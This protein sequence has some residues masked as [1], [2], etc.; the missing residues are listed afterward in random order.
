MKRY[1]FLYLIVY[2]K[3]VIIYLFFYFLL[4][5]HNAAY[6]VF[7][8]L[9]PAL[10]QIFFSIAVPP[11]Q[12]TILDR[13]GRILNGTAGPYEEGDTPYLTCRVTGGKLAQNTVI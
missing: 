10:T 8:F 11:E 9:E 12:P 5:F 4:F 7:P 2:W 1:I 3:E 6:F 13:W